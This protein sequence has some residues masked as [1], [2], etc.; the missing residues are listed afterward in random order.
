M[1]LK[2]TSDGSDVICSGVVAF[3]VVFVDVDVQ[4]SAT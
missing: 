4:H 3:V 2:D 1:D